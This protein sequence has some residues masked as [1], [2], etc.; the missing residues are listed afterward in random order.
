MTDEL[1]RRTFLRGAAGT[2][3]VAAV[4][5]CSS[6]GEGGGAATD[7]SMDDGTTE[8]DS[9]SGMTET[10]A[11]DGGMTET[12]AMDG[13]MTETD[14]MDGGMEETDGMGTET[15]GGMMSTATFEVTVTNVSDAGTITTSEGDDVAVPL[16]PAA[17][18]VHTDD[19]TAF[20]SGAAA[21]DGLESLAED[22]SPDAFAA[23]VEMADGVET[24]GTVA[25]PDGADGAAPLMPGDSYTVEV[26]AGHDHHLTLA[27]MFVQSNDLFYAPEPSGIAL[28]DGGEPVEGDVTDQ[29]VLWD[30]GT[31][32]NQEP[33][34]GPDQ[35]PRQ[36]GAD[37]GPEEMANVR[38]IDEVMDEYSYPDTSEVIEVTVT[39][40]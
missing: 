39:T 20:E 8:T 14:A 11:M 27:T 6:D 13:G 18:A 3:A 16:S 34:V 33:G 1:D 30:A 31:E 32:M 12:D 5:G 22:G 2:L 36:D 35:A 23:E 4:A 7:E 17:Y 21:S 38:P 40:M 19:A 10:D 25:T 24:A 15:E 37:T 29:L 28:F 26:E 9:M